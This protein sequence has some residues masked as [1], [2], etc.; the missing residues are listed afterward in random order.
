MIARSRIEA[1]GIIEQLGTTNTLIK[2]LV[3]LQWDVFVGIASNGLAQFR[4]DS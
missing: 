3:S 4:S 2:Y 1:G